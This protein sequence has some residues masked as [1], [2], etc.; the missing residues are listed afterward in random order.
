MKLTSKIYLDHNATSSLTQSV[1]DWVIKDPLLANSHSLHSMG[2]SSKKLVNLTREFLFDLFNLNSDNFDLFFHSGATEGINTIIQGVAQY[3]RMN[4]ERGIHLFYSSVDHSSVRAIASFLV[5]INHDVSKFSVD[6]NGDFDCD[7]LIE[8]IKKVI[9]GGQQVL[10]NF[11]F[12]NNETGVV[13]PIEL[14][15]R[16]KRETGCLVHVDAVQAVGRIDNAFSLSSQLDAYTFSGHKFG[17]LTGIGFTF[18]RKDFKFSPLLYGGGTDIR[19]G[20]ENV[21]SI[22]SLRL[23]LEEIKFNFNFDK[24]LAAKIEFEKRLKSL[25]TSKGVIVSA[26]AK[27]RNANTIFFIIHGVRSDILLAAFDMAG[28]EVSSGSACS[29]GSAGPNKVI[30]AMGHS[31]GDA[32]SGIRL[33]FP[34]TFSINQVDQYFDKVSQVLKKFL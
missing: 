20:S 3:S 34:P 11:T 25:I 12:V 17:A 28:V 5:Q 2:K 33:S 8:D 1:L 16:I 24:L 15:E 7:Q 31:D 4:D 21:R 10:L 23:A 13:W 6:A 14:A 29:S 27:Y 30:K 18:F 19:P 26:A 9:S 22:Y 32:L